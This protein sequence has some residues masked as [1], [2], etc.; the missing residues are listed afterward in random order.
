MT[1]VKRRGNGDLFPALRNDL[2]ELFDIE[3][4]L[5]EPFIESP[6]WNRVSHTRIPAANIVETEKEFLV[7]LAAP[8]L[9]KKDFKVDVDNNVLEIK[10]EKE[11]ETKEDRERYTRREYNYKTFYRS[12]TLPDSVTPDKIKAEYKN[13][14]L[15]VHLPKMAETKKKQVKEI[16]VV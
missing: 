14:L 16:A 3:R 9:D 8:G 4:S 7:E 11:E 15:Q 2:T 13:G 1:L 6:V 5:L 10:V 12:F